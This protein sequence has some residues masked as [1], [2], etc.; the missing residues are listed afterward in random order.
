MPRKD[1]M[2]RHASSPLGRSIGFSGVIRW[3]IAV[4]AIIAVGAGFAAGRSALA[5]VG[6]LFFAAAITLNYRA[7]R[8]RRAAEASIKPPM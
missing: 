6:L 1:D 3:L 8:A 2:S 4:A 5:I 7:W